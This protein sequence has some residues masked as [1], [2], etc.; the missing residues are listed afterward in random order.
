MAQAILDNRTGP[1]RRRGPSLRTLQVGN[2]PAYRVKRVAELTDGPV[3]APAQYAPNLPRLVTVIDAKCFIRISADFALAANCINHGEPLLQ[4]YSVPI[5][6]FP[7][8]GISG[9]F[10]ICSLISIE[11]VPESAS[12]L[13]SV[14]PFFP[15][16]SLTSRL[17]FL[18]FTVEVLWP[19]ALEL[20]STLSAF[21]NL[22][23]RRHLN[24]IT[25][26][27]HTISTI[28]VVFLICFKQ[29]S[30]GSS[31]TYMDA[32]LSRYLASTSARADCSAW[33]AIQAPGPV[34][35][36]DPGAT[37]LGQGHGTP[38]E[39]SSMG[40]RGSTLGA[41]RCLP[42]G[43]SPI[44]QL[45]PPGIV[46]LYPAPMIRCWRSRI[47]APTCRRVQSPRRDTA[48][49]M[50]I[51]HASNEGRSTEAPRPVSRT[52]RSALFTKWR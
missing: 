11:I 4:I 25:L 52:G 6:Q 48:L 26:S 35:Y 29:P 34:S 14:P 44:R 38:H 43:Q 2:G 15:S 8:A 19:P 27:G 30:H 32:P 13:F 50:P 36:D 21:S 7:V 12:L 23:P 45:G 39:H 24:R 47:T 28:S 9:S 42:R 31:V 3:A 37:A 18:G 1:S 20:I 17:A 10:S 49:A 16:H 40:P 22:R 5:S 51:A 41:L 33:L 46:P